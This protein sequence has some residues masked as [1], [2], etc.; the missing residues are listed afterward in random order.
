MSTPA[1]YYQNVPDYMVD[2]YDWAYVNPDHARLL[3]HR[4]VVRTL[5]F[6]NDGRLMQAYLDAVQP[7]MRVWQ[8][9]H[10][11]GN[12]VQRVAQKLGPGGEFHLCDVT[13][14]QVELARAK[15]AGLPQATVWQ[16]DAARFDVGGGYD[17][18]CSFFLLHEVPDDYKRAIVAN[19]LRQL[20]PGG[21][22]LF[23]DYHRP[24]P[25]QPIGWLLRGVN[26]WLEPYALALWRHPIRD[27]AAD[28]DDFVWS[29]RTLFG[30]VYQ[31]VS[32]TR[33]R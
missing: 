24:A 21:R 8:V 33:R 11:Y 1:R 7:G 13:P 25:W 10:V 32:A 14:V 30:G 20:A 16:A 4:C 18:V 23:V 26:H 9:A 31:V 22:A 6:G 3:D 12:L 28:A 5:L 29:Q 2:V 15:L 17:L 19:M 27:Y